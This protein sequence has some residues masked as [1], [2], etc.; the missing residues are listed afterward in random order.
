MKHEK[1][2]GVSLREGGAKFNRMVTPWHYCGGRWR[3]RAAAA[4]QAAAGKE[5]QLSKSFLPHAVRF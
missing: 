4:A 5:R 1:E 3:E 2:H